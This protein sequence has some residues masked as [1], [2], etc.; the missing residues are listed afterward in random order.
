MRIWKELEMTRWFRFLNRAY[1]VYFFTYAVRTNWPVD[2]ARCGKHRICIYVDPDIWKIK[3]PDGENGNIPLYL[4]IEK[5]FL[6][7]FTEEGLKN[8]SFPVCDECYER[9]GIPGYSE[10]YLDDRERYVFPDTSFNII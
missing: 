8:R 5:F 2:C 6:S 7:L 3:G 9:D 10:D 4:I 1:T